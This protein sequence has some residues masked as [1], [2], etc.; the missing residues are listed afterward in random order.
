MSIF[1]FLSKCL[2]KKITA[3]NLRDT[4]ITNQILNKIPLA[5][6]AKWC[7]TSVSEIEKK[8]F[9]ISQSNFKPK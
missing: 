6:I 1:K 8:Y 4:F 9:D 7:D 3:Y 5:V 2:G